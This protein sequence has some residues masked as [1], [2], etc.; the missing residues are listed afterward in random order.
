MLADQSAEAVAVNAGEVADV[1]AVSLQPAH[2]RILRIEEPILT[3][4]HAAR[5]EWP[6]VADL[7]GATAGT[8]A[9]A[10]VEA[11]TAPG[12][13]GLPSRV[14]G[15]EEDVRVAGIVSHHKENVARPTGIRAY[16]LGEVDAGACGGGHGPRG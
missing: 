9:C 16:R 2:H 1:I 10:L 12:V 13:V 8:R 15:L 14:R 7:V 4:I 6:V 5:T 11:V 3:A